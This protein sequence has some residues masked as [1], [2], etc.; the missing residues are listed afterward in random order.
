MLEASQGTLLRAVPGDVCCHCP[1]FIKADSE[2]YRLSLI[3]VHWGP[4]GRARSLSQT[5]WP[6]GPL[7]P[8]LSSLHSV[9]AGEP[10]EGWGGRGSGKWGGTREHQGKWSLWVGP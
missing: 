4:H 5:C 1:G 6:P 2:A 3:Q 10:R 8:H 7:P 9:E